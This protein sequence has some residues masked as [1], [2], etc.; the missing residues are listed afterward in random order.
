M[1]NFHFRRFQYKAVWHYVLIYCC[2]LQILSI[3][4]YNKLKY[5]NRGRSTFKCSYIPYW[6]I[7]AFHMNPYANCD[8]KNKSTS[9]ILNTA[10]LYVKLFYPDWIQDHKIDK[11]NPCWLFSLWEILYGKR[12]AKISRFP[13]KLSI[14]KKKKKIREVS[15]K[16]VR[17]NSFSTE[18]SLRPKHVSV[19]RLKTK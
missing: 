10:N 15:I 14:E 12:F 16:M 9:S 1:L 19:G 6:Y 8:P 17:S 5:Y 3:I 7:K 2:Y 4:D 18:F 13:F 11:S